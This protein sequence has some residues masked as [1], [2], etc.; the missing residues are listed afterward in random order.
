MESTAYDIL[1]QNIDKSSSNHTIITSYDYER[2]KRANQIISSNKSESLTLT[3][4]SNSNEWEILLN[5]FTYIDYN[6]NRFIDF[7]TYILWNKSIP[8]LIN[9]PESYEDYM[10]N[11]KNE[12]LNSF[13]QKNSVSTVLTSILGRIYNE[14]L[15][16][17]LSRMKNKS[18]FETIND[19]SNELIELLTIKN[20][21][22]DK[23]SNNPRML[24]EFMNKCL[25]HRFPVNKSINISSLRIPINFSYIFDYPITQKLSS[26]ETRETLNIPPSINLF[27]KLFTSRFQTVPL[28]LYLRYLPISRNISNYRNDEP[29]T[30]TIED[31][32]NMI[33]SLDT[34]LLIE[35]EPI[36]SNKPTFALNTNNNNL[37]QAF[38]DLLDTYNKPNMFT[39]NFITYDHYLRELFIISSNLINSLDI[40]KSFN[41]LKY[42]TT[43]HDFTDEI[44]PLTTYN[45]L[46]VQPPKQD[47]TNKPNK[48]VKPST[49]D[50]M[51][52]EP[53]YIT[54]S[55]SFKVF[56]FIS[57]IITIIIVIIIY[58][59]S[60][61]VN[62]KASNTIDD[63]MKHIQ[64]IM[65]RRRFNL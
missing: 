21:E 42:L 41:I 2:S 27:N 17:T 63:N 33:N 14:N 45:I 65:L 19:I 37:K 40:A 3:V 29:Q 5:A 48:E 36:T 7:D 30:I 24:M 60:R 43:K 58:N 13:T 31:N 50:F 38:I 8:K 57:F 55:T 32:G 47:I 54:L 49:F 18:H 9:Y 15:I 61:N 44:K 6:N 1:K 23:E 11:F 25:K 56:M 16:N 46:T 22:Y 10:N 59:K 64:T 35:H 34:T 62:F 39:I 51:F 12:F 52:V 4:P 26:S 53:K 28:Q 20:I